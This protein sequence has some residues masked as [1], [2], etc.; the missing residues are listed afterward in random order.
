LWKDGC[1]FVK[2]ENIV[3]IIPLWL[4]ILPEPAVLGEGK[5]CAKRRPKKTPDNDPIHLCFSLFLKDL[6]PKKL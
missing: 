3:K 1:V 2:D 4:G 6:A 5:A